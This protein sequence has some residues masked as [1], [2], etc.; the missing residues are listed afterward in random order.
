MR[1]RISLLLVLPALA[2]AGSGYTRYC[3]TD[4]TRRLEVNVHGA[5]EFSDDDRDVK[6][7]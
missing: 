3:W 2:L 4:G 6:S 7:L 1:T 5:V